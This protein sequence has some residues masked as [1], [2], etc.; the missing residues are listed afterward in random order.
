[1][2]HVIKFFWG[3]IQDP[4]TESGGKYPTKVQL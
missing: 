4:E 3:E 2:V 1:M